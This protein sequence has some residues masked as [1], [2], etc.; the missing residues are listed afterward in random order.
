MDMNITHVVRGQ[1]HLTNTAKHV[2]LFEALGTPLPSFAHLPLIHGED[3]SKLS[4]RNSQGMTTVNDFREAGYLPEALVNFLVLL[5]WSHPDEQEQLTIE[6]AIAAFDLKR[7]N[8]T[9]AKFEFPKLNFLNS[10]WIKHLPE[11]R[12]AADARRFALDYEESIA[13][14]GEG[15]WQEAIAQ[16]RHQ[17][18]TLADVND[19]AELLFS[20]ALELDPAAKE[21]FSP[22]E[23]QEG[24]QTVVTAWREQL[25]QQPL[26]DGRDCYT[27]E[28]FKA[29]LKT[30]KK[31]LPVDAKTVFQ[32]LRVAVTGALS[33]PDLDVLVPLVTRNTLR[34]RAEGMQQLL[35]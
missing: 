9:A 35:A 8:Q 23:A 1:D 13:Q 3:G 24:F 33:G 6:E 25:E 30:L 12:I 29:M 31:S 26:E 14:R 21:R 20:L 2:V 27:A 34:E 28:Q 17:L 15:Y 5:G 16:R 11:E 32:S 10:W 19:Y 7:I 18:T 22:P 4:K